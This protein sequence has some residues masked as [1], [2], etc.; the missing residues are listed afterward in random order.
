MIDEPATPLSDVSG[1]ITHVFFALPAY[2]PS[3][4]VPLLSCF[5]A[6]RDALGPGVRCTVLRRPAQAALV[7]EYLGG[8]IS[9]D[10]IAWEEGFV[11]RLA[12]TTSTVD[13][14]TLRIT[15]LALP[16]FTS[17]VQDP[18]LVA[19]GVNGDRLVW[20]SPRVRRQ[21][22]GWDDVVPRRLAEHL[23]WR[24]EKL[25]CAIEAGNLLLDDHAALVGPDVPARAAESEW[26][27]LSRLLTSNGRRVVVAA[28]GR[29]QP[30]FHLDLYLTLAG[31]HATTGRPI[32]LVGSVRRA[33]EVLGQPSRNDDPDEGLD[34]L[35]AQMTADGYR[36]ERLPLLP[37]TTEG[38]PG[39]G[40]YSYNN[41]LVELFGGVRTMT[42]RVVLPAYGAGGSDM[43]GVLDGDAERVWT[44]TGFE[45]RVARSAFA[46]LAERGGSVRCM[47]KVLERDNVETTSGSAADL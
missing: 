7:E 46:I 2:E 41:C 43:L 38:A 33:R 29:S 25:P 18:F 31:P 1:R 4:V 11:L 3:F 26:N 17:W 16:D 13:G 14:S 34:A 10:T 36:V 35:A 20:A 37:F 5:R 8:Q 12:D 15:R 30:V 42:R 32:A 24:Y 22:G 47:T 45:V 6:I 40:W 27:T 9:L 39:R 21:H 19:V 28:P 23:S 44:D